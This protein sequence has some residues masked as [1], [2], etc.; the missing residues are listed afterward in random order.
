MDRKA[1]TQTRTEAGRR[2]G[3][4]LCGAVTFTYEG[5][6]IWCAHCHCESCRRTTS[7]PFTTFVG[8]PRAAVTFAG[9]PPRVYCS[10]PGVRRSFCGDCGAPIAYESTR[11]PGEIHLYACCLDAPGEVT[12]QRH[13]HTAEQLAWIALADGL[14]RYPHDGAA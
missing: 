11:Y 8:L 10:S 12:P 1:K 4:C 2:S 3:G 13:V 5:A 14:P 7:S 9:A 6:E